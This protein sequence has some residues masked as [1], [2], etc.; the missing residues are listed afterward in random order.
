MKKMRI[1]S[2]VLAVLMLGS[3]LAL[4]ASCNGRSEKPTTD[5]E[6]VISAEQAEVDLSNYSVVYGVGEDGVTNTFKDAA[7]SFVDLL[8]AKSGLKLKLQSSSTSS[9]T[10]NTPEILIGKTNRAESVEALNGIEGYGYTI[11]VINNKI[12]VVG[13]TNVLTMKALEY[14]EDKY[15][16]DKSVSTMLTLPQSAVASNVEV[17]TLADRENSNFSYVYSSELDGNG[18]YE[19]IPW[20]GGTGNDYTYD[21]VKD[22][23]KAIAGAIGVAQRKLIQKV[24][25]APADGAEVLIG[26]TTRQ[27]STTCRAELTP[28]EY[29]VFVRDGN[30]VVTAWN[31]AGLQLCVALFLDLVADSKVTDGTNTSVVM[32]AKFE[33]KG[34]VD[35][36][37]ITDFPKPTGNGINLFASADGDNDSLIY[38]YMGD[39][40]NA[41]AYNSYCETLKADGYKVLTQS[42]IEGSMFATL[43]NE[44]KGATLYVA[45][46]AFAHAKDSVYTSSGATY[47]YDDP[48]IRIVSAPLK[49]VTLPGEELLSEQSYTKVTDSAF[50]SV[51]LPSGSVGTCH[52]AM[53]ED[54]RFVIMDGGRQTSANEAKNIWNVLVDLY[55]KQQGN[56]SYPTEQK[57]IRIAAWILSHSHTDHYQAFAEFAKTYGKTGRVEMEYLLGNFPSKSWIYNTGEASTTIN[58]KIGEWSNMFKKPFTFLK[59]HTGQKLYFANLEIEVLFTVEDMLPHTIINL[60]D[61]S[62]V[63]RL[64]LQPHD[65][66]MQKAGDPVSLIYAGD[67][68]RYGGRWVCAMYGDYLKSDMVSMSHHRGPGTEKLFYQLIAPEVV[69]VPHVWSSYDGYYTAQNQNGWFFKVNKYVRYELETVKYIV[70]AET[71]NATLFFRPTGP[72]YDHF[73][74]AANGG[75]VPIGPFNQ[76]G[77]TTI[78][79]K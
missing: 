72:D 46:D 34:I 33:S 75:E 17:L 18:Q 29:G 58:E 4:L 26:F 32:P 53:L 62:P 15:L 56:P 7:L 37:W 55:S 76:Q 3:T 1:L 67:S 8:N 39:G 45:F 52:I 6:W 28:N 49:S 41:N 31:D 19:E 66:S 79:K 64:S 59:I 40:V 9:T 11:R 36:D 74:A 63:L 24:D 51:V 2:L 60:N 77:T 61:A 12:V 68:F 13:S 20:D 14:F 78:I 21:A 23:T 30:I 43:V 73:Y 22:I 69:W 38:V 50:T 71:Y 25:S 48:T 10:A 57:P 35:P 47:K 27:L 16:K 44:A 42:T 70:V 5:G 54:G 65:A